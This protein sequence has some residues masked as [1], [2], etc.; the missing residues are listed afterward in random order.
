MSGIIKAEVQTRRSVGS[1]TADQWFRIGPK[2]AMG[3]MACIIPSCLSF[4]VGVFR[5]AL[6][7]LAVSMII[8]RRRIMQVAEDADAIRRSVR[9]RPYAPPA[10]RNIGNV[11]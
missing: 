10:K 2:S 7:V 9:E 8:T 11:G 1:V 5:Q 3:T 6:R 4:S